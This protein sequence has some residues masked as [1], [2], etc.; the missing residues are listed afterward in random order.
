M[1]IRDEVM[2]L[3][4][5]WGG[6]WPA[7]VLITA[8]NLRIFDHLKTSKTAAE[9]AGMIKSDARATEILLDAV[10]GLG[11]I[12][13]SSNKYRNTSAANR[14]LVSGMP[15]YQG[16]ILRHAD[17]L[18]DNWSHLD[19]IVRNGLPS[20]KSFE[21]DA[22]IR[23]MHN[24][25][26][27]KAPEVIKNIGLKG[28]KKALDLGGGPGT[29]SIEMAK[30]V[31]SVTLFDRPETVTIA[32]DVIGKTRLKNISFIEG[33]FLTDSIGDG[34]DLIFISQILHSFSETK[35]LGIIK[36]SYDALTPGGLI[37]IQEHLLE[38]DRTR[39][40]SGSL[41]SVNMLVNTHGG[42]SYSAQEIKRWL[43]STGFKKVKHRVKE[44][45]NLVFGRKRRIAGT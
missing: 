15:Y 26:S 2:G 1:N 39:P 9:I 33:D 29:Y 12:K 5:L 44:D 24:I 10:A 20:L 31:K 43:S 17:N 23:G 42:R 41:F 35:N 25:A 6:Y 22:F 13:K 36:K 34:Y 7:R 30:K 45:S 21:T 19:E 14:L 40:V 27:L 16:D 28:V 38:Q 3:R 18:W 37:V 4:M 8:S 11:L 32:K